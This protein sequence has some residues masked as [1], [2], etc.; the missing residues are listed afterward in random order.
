MSERFVQTKI[1]ELPQQESTMSEA[2][3]T[4]VCVTGGNGYLGSWVVFYLLEQ[5]YNVKCTVRSLNKE[6]S[7]KHL[8]GLPGAT[9]DHRLEICEAR[10]EDKDTWASVLEG[11]Q[12]IIH[13]ASPRPHFIPEDEMDLVYPAL[14][15][16]IG[17]MT[18]ALAMKINKIILTGDI[19]NVRGAKYSANY[20]EDDWA[21]I[22]PKLSHYE[23]SK[24][25]AERCALNFTQ[26][27]HKNCETIVL[28]P[29]ALLGPTLQDHCNNASC[30]FFKNL[31]N[32]SQSMLKVELPV[33]DVRDAAQAH[34]NALDCRIEIQQRYIV[35]NESKWYSDL[36]TILEEK[37]KK[38]GYSFPKATIG[39]FY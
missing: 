9:D 11:C 27:Q 3:I 36:V 29:G 28:L 38:Y 23:K 4:K 24:I 7:Y 25:L 14:E 30:R 31:F 39:K 33:C 6:D 2:P 1:K 19:C 13:C 16:T 20:T 10:L 37:Y 32:D 35:F 26:E 34:V 17:I 21:D 12:A 15:G 22:D 5:G 8:M 18:T